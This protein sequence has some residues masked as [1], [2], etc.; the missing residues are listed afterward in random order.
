MC[1]RPSI[2]GM[3]STKAPKSVMRCTRPMYDLLS[4]GLAVSSLMISIA[5]WAEASSDDATFTCPSS[6]TL[7]LTP[8]RSMMLLI[9]FPPGPMTSRILSTGIL[10]VTIRG[11]YVEMSSRKAG[12]VP[13]ILSRMCSLPTR[14]CSSAS[15]MISVVMPAT[16]MSI[17]RAV[18]PF[19]VPATLKSM[20]P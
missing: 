20:S 7:I 18:I 19:S 3:I 1:S 8:V 4:S 10:T 2:P 5:F 13:L 17:C 9:I 6:S 14:A 15:R 12:K 16:L 11:A